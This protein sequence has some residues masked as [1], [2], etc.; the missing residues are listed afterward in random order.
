M[1]NIHENPSELHEHFSP[2]DTQKT[3]KL[4]GN[5]ILPY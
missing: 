3:P 1:K 5:N 4:K 2:K